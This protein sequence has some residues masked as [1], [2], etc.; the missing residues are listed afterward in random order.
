MKA[1]YIKPITIVLVLVGSLLF[2]R[3]YSQ[4]EEGSTRYC[5][6]SGTACRVKK[7]IWIDLQKDKNGDT[8]TIKF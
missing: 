6:G 4:S 2:F 8:I 5:E 3:S 7:I 1:K